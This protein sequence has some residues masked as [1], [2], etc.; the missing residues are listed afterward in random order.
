MVEKRRREAEALNNN[1]PSI[2]KNR[3]RSYLT[4]APATSASSSSSSSIIHNP[5]KGHNSDRMMSLRQSQPSTHT[6]HNNRNGF[7][8]WVVTKTSINNNQSEPTSSS[9]VLITSCLTL[10]ALTLDLLPPHF[11]TSDLCAPNPTST[12]TSHPLNNGGLNL[13]I[14]SLSPA[15][16][17]LSRFDAVAATTAGVAPTVTQS[18]ANRSMSTITNSG[19]T[20]T[21]NIDKSILKSHDT[22]P[23]SQSLT[24]FPHPLHAWSS[25]PLPPSIATVVGVVKGGEI[26]VGVVNRG[27]GALREP[28][29][30]AV[31]YD[32]PIKKIITLLNKIMTLLY[33]K[34]IC[35]NTVE[36]NDIYT[37][38]AG[39]VCRL[40]QGSGG[41]SHLTG[42]IGHI[43]LLLEGSDDEAYKPSLNT[44][45]NTTNTNSGGLGLSK[46][47]LMPRSA[48]SPAIHPLTSSYPLSTPSHTTSP[49]PPQLSQ[50]TSSSTHKRKRGT[51][52][53]SLTGPL[54]NNNN[55]NNSNCDY[56]D[57]EDTM[58]GGGS[59][60]KSKA[61]TPTSILRDV[62]L[63]STRSIAPSLLLALIIGPYMHTNIG[64][65]SAPFS[66]YSYLSYQK[67]LLKL[68][69]DFVPDQR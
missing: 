16:L 66:S 24:R 11:A 4:S 63:D 55:N 21:T 45:S 40:I 44:T 48:V 30:T 61:V 60:K 26:G 34:L 68:L 50:P 54:Y 5:V 41:V 9:S 37:P 43:L 56:S 64:H 7:M 28:T 57:D 20:V 3:P 67:S 17:L 12:S 1:R 13:P 33:S 8:N 62:S 2:L 65:N 23:S 46:A 69:T 59:N 6:T 35:E 27:E 22:L 51:R 31:V 36:S 53:V 18:V 29:T 47:S 42:G 58:Q 25:V 15:N 49:P 39:I 10:I 32:I 19:G 38:L 52:R 14:S